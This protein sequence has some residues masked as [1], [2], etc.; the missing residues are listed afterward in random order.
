MTDMYPIMIYAV[1]NLKKTMIKTIGIHVEMLT[2]LD[3]QAA[4]G[5]LQIN[6]LP[7]RYDL[8]IAFCIE[9]LNHR[10]K[11]YN[12]CWGTLI[13]FERRKSNKMKYLSKP[14]LVPDL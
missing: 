11:Q 8:A 13:K 4:L 6:K 12:I 14:D 10:I 9:V 2:K 1:F 3:V 7:W 5:Y